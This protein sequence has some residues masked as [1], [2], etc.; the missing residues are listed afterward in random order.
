MALSNDEA[1]EVD[2]A[3]ITDLKVKAY[4]IPTE[5]PESDGS[6]R[7]D[8]TTLVLVRVK[9]G[10]VEGIGYTYGNAAIAFLIENTLKHLVLERNALNPPAI[11]KKLRHQLRNE[12]FCGLATMA[13]S[14]IDTALWDLKAKILGLPLAVL[15][16]LQRNEA[17]IY[18][19][20]GFTSYTTE[21]LQEQFSRWSDSGF[22]YVKM[23][24]GRDAAADRQRV[25]EARESISDSCHLMV[26]ANGAYDAKTAI[27]QAGAFADYNVM[28]F[29]EPVSSDDLAGLQFIR[30]RVPDS[31]NVAAGEY[32]YTPGYFKN[33]LQHN[34]VDILQADATRCGGYTGF[35]K[36]AELAA[37][38]HKPFSFHCAPALHLSAALAVPEFFIGEYFFDHVRIENMLFDGAPQPKNGR[39][40]VDLSK[41][42]CGLEFKEQ[43]ARQFEVF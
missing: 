28:W 27:S 41:P 21:Q 13:V 35:F 31:I 29:E 11:W 14:A 43:D 30:S 42:G 25:S 7:W 3:K 4:T 24:I 9:S 12:G 22:T 19:S 17:L 2:E 34:A 38:F 40:S 26:D 18:G 32:G 37:A 8:S 23:K 39:I 5:T 20:G 36:A 1:I 33:M 16:G 15:F 6:F 10:A